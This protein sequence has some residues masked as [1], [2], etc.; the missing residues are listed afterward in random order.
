ME[1]RNNGIDGILK[2]NWVSFEW[3]SIELDWFECLAQKG[4]NESSFC[5]GKED[6]IARKT[7]VTSSGH[8]NPDRNRPNYSQISFQTINR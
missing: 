5:G 6:L 4:E 2:K 7:P 1:N 8:L 3:D